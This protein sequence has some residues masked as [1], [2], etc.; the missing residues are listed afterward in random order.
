[1]QEGRE[2]AALKWMCWKVSPAPEMSLETFQQQSS[3][4]Q[5]ELVFLTPPPWPPWLLR[6]MECEHLGAVG[7]RWGLEGSPEL[8]PSAPSSHARRHSEGSGDCCA[9]PAANGCTG[10]SRGQDL[11]IQGSEV[12]RS[13]NCLAVLCRPGSFMALRYPQ[14]IAAPLGVLAAAS[15]QPAP[16]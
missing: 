16:C 15:C 11:G 4:P 14:T 3:T 9:S 13:P 7:V 2:T 12:V 8:Q 6:D 10:S 5:A 1:M